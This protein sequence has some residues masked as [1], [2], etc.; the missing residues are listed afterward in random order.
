MINKV[1]QNGTLNPPNPPRE[2]IVKEPLGPD[3]PT[4]FWFVNQGFSVIPCYLGTKIPKIKWGKYQ[5]QLPTHVE[6]LR[7]FHT[8]SN[9]AIVTGTNNLVVIDFDSLTEYIKWSLWAG[10]A[11]N[12]AQSILRNAY[13]VRTSRGIHVYT[14][15]T[16]NIKNF[17]FDKIDIKGK[18]GLVT[19]PGSIHPSGAVYT[20]YQEGIFPTWS[21]LTEIFPVGMVESL[22]DVKTYKRDDRIVSDLSAADVLDMKVGINVNDVKRAHRIEDYISDIT[23]T[24]DHWGVAKCPFHGEDSHPSM[25]IDTE[26]QLCGCFTCTPMPMDVIN[27]YARLNHI[28]NTE[29][30][31]RLGEGI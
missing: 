16:G 14:R 25:W 17:H 21:S 22:E 8:P 24:G 19:L 5:S 2:E 6:L 3:L 1:F 30:I 12:V 9:A 18:G 4:I 15:C 31:R 10:M 11:G 7:W 20:V 29:A 27:L 26:K 13:K 23:F 28:S